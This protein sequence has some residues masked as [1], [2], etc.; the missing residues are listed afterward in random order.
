MYRKSEENFQGLKKPKR[1]IPEKNY[2]V[3]KIAEKDP[4][5]PK[6]KYQSKKPN[7]SPPKKK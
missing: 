6:E 5:F 7:N 2:K 4:K 1:K 3:R